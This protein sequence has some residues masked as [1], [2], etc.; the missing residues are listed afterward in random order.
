VNSFGEDTGLE[1]AQSDYVMGA[2]LDLSSHLQLVSQ[3][4]IDEDDLHVNRHDLTVT[5]TYGPFIASANYV[6]ADAQPALGFDEP[7][8]EIAAAA[9][10]KLAAN[11]TLY[12]DIR[13]DLDADDILRN[14]IGLKYSDECFVLSVTYI[15]SNITDGDD[16]RPD[17]TVLVRYNLLNVGGSNTR[18]DNIG[19]FSSELPVVK[20]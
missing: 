10:V 6:N 12:G 20:Y 8:E 7:R 9:A 14:S 4:R 2:Y 19:T 1:N 5:G 13:Y 16:I 18:T 17:Q 15:D 3:V 11:W